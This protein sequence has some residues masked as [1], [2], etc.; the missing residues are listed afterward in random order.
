M[1]GL[2]F[3]FGHS[4]GY[5]ERRIGVDCLGVPVYANRKGGVEDAV[6]VEVAPPA[7][8]I[9]EWHDAARSTIRAMC[10]ITH[11]AILNFLNSPEFVTDG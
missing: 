4:D 9:V 2:D 7:T 6:V 10:A 8:G 5:G 3:L 11:H 1:R